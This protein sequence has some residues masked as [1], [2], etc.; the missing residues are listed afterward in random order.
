MLNLIALIFGILHTLRKLDV[1]RRVHSDYPGVS[2]EDF[3]AWQASERFIYTV[4]S[5]ACWLK[6]LLG[7]AFVWYVSRGTSLS[8]LWIRVIGG[9]ID[10]SW[11][12]V[13]VWALVAGA[14][15]RRRREELGIVLGSTP[16]KD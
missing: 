7:W 1:T 4:S 14:R 6:I 10:I 2:A 11:M 13:L 16:R 12:G 9:G 15:A 8:G 3:H 5:T